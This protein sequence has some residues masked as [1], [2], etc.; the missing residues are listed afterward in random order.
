MKYV[1]LTVTI[2]TASVKIVLAYYFECMEI[3]YVK[4]KSKSMDCG[5]KIKDNFNFLKMKKLSNPKC[6]NSNF[7]ILRCII[8]DAEIVS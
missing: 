8:L 5:F 6:L 2:K 1:V 4:M 7:T 3:C